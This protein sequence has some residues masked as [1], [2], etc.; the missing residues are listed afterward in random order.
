[1]LTGAAL[2]LFLPA[3]GIEEDEGESE[4]TPH[5]A[6]RRAPKPATA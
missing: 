5:G 1:V 4:E 2:L 6:A 3:N